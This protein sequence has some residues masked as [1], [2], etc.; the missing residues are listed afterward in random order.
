MSQKKKKN[1]KIVVPDERAEEILWECLKEV[2]FL[3]E[4]RVKVEQRLISEAGKADIE[5]RVRVG[6]NEKVIFAIVKD[7][8]QARMVRE[9]IA[10]LGKACQ[11]H[12]ASYG[13]VIAPQ[14]AQ[15]AMRVCRQEGVGYIDYSGNCYLNFDFVFISKA[16]R[17][18][19]VEAR[20]K[21]RSWYSP[22]A[23]R[24]VRTLLLHPKRVWQIRELANESLVTPNQ[25]LHIKEHLAQW[26]WVG[27]ER[28]GFRLVEPSLLL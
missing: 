12:A 14:I 9:A 28:D 25:A 11:N 13:V 22:R 20:K 26:F 23:E 27:E 1:G 8:G 19:E 2:P 7:N 4:N 3:L 6:D 18:S 5:A 16:G 24:V 21:S 15:E 10:D 17:V